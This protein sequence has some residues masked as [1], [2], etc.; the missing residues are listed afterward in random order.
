MKTAPTTAM[1]IAR[2]P[3]WKATPLLVLAAED[4]LLVPLAVPEAD[5]LPEAEAVSFADPVSELDPFPS[6]F[7]A[8]TSSLTLSHSSH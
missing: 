4:P 7:R 5:E 6:A 3:T 8:T 2:N 1:A